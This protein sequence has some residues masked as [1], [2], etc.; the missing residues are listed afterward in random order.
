VVRG[1][2]TDSAMAQ[3]M[4]VGLGTLSTYLDNRIAGS[5]LL[6][7]AR[8]RRRTPKG[9]QAQDKKILPRHRVKRIG[10]TGSGSVVK[11]ITTGLA[12]A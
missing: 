8:P 10:H 2:T 6:R 11:G 4:R 1:I 9:S 12:T 3:A 5:R 7:R